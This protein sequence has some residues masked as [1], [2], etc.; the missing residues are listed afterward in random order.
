MRFEPLADP[1][2]ALLDLLAHAVWITD[3]NDGRILW[4]NR[5]AVELWRAEDLDELLN[6]DLSPSPTMRDLLHQLGARTAAGERVVQERTI[7]PKGE[8]TRIEMVI[9]AFPVPDE[10]RV[11]LIEARRVQGLDPEAVRASEAVRYAPLVVAT[12]FPTGETLQANTRARQVF[13]T[14]LS[15]QSI[16]AHPEEAEHALSQIERGDIVSEDVEVQTIA[17]LRFYAIE[18]RRISDPVTGKPAILMSAHDMTARIEAERAKEDLISVVSHELRTPL[19]AMR[20]ALELISGGVAVGQ[21]ELEA[22]LLQIALENTTRLSRLVDDLLDVRKLAAG[23]ISLAVAEANLCDVVR[24]AVELYTPVARTRA[25]DI[26][27]STPDALPIVMD[28]CRIQQVVTNLVSNAVKHSPP[29]ETVKVKVTRQGD[30]ARVS[31]ID[32]GPGVPEAFRNRIF[33]RFSQADAS[34]TR[35]GSGTGLG[36]YI[37]KT[38]MDLHGGK[39]GFESPKEGG[40]TFFFDLACKVD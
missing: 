15:F 4:A 9:G 36:L 23:G 10:R 11:I 3:T 28:V 26:E 1:R 32:R 39:L 35:A 38:I 21:P 5:A 33:L 31:V 30:T 29:G 8:A 16:F 22:E 12:F 2:L 37:A 19:T 27:V 14:D 6:R 24:K 17:G 20:G 40:A 13:G 25:V 18:A 34:S 7:F